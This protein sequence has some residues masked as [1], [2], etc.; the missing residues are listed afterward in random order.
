MFSCGATLTTA[1]RMLDGEANGQPHDPDCR[2]VGARDPRRRLAS[3]RVTELEKKRPPYT[4]EA[5]AA[6]RFW[7]TFLA[8]LQRVA[9]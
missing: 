9:A 7:E 4:G 3:I 5:R 2:L 1:E 6:I 8:S